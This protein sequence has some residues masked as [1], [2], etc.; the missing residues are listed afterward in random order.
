MHCD[1]DNCMK[2]AKY[3]LWYYSYDLQGNIHDVDFSID[4]CRKHIFSLA[5]GTTYGSPDEITKED[6]ECPILLKKILK[7]FKEGT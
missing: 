2:Q 6:R 4:S 5:K 3:I 7:K 1:Y